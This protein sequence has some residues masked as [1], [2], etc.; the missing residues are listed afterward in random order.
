VTILLWA[1][2]FPAISIGV[3]HVDPSG[4]A[5]VRFAMAAAVGGLWLA[6]RKERL[7][8]A[9]DFCRILVSSLLGIAL[10]NVLINTGQQTVSPGAASFIVATQTVFAATLAHLMGQ[11]KVGSA[12]VAGTALSLAGVCVISLGQEPST[13]FGSGTWLVLIAAAC[14]GASFVLQ[15]PLAV[16]HGGART[17]SWTL[18]VG[19]LLLAPWL[20]QGL[21]Q[22]TGSWE[23]MAAVSFLALGSGVVG[24][25][26]WLRALAGLGA[27]R[28]ANLLFLMAP[29]TL[30]LAIPITGHIP[31]LL[32]ILGG[33]AALGG[34]AIVNRSCRPA[35]AANLES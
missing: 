28:A 24:Y 15:R 23:A 1:G 12:W 26:C 25:A 16:K 4:L 5:A 3:R 21:E 35:P 17:A 33:A 8:S 27:A 11:E 20:P 30:I 2:S 9:A 32:T 34:V 10:Y 6:W 14:S 13:R 31:E 29:T 22:S 18:V 7:P 19:G